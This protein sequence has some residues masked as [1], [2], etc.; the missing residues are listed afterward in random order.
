MAQAMVAAG[1]AHGVEFVGEAL[2]PFGAADFTAAF[3]AAKDKHPTLV[4]LNLYG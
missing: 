2:V 1:Q 4:V 3:T